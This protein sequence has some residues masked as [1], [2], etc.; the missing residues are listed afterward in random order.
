MKRGRPNRVILTSADEREL[1]KLYLQSNRTESGGSATMAARV[2]AGKNP[3]LAEALAARASKHDL[4]AAV[5]KAVEPAKRLVKLHREG[6]KGL[7]AT[8]GYNPG[9]MRLSEDGSRRL[10]AGEQICADDGTINFGVVVPWPWGGCKCS[11]KFGVKLGRF[12][13]LLMHDDATSLIPCW[14]YIIRPSQSY[15]AADVAGL[16]LRFC[17]DICL[18]DRALFEGGNWQSKRV[19]SALEALGIEL[20]DVKGRPNQKLVENFF[21]RLWT[22]ISIESN[23]SVGRFREDDRLGQELY[24]AGQD[25]RKDPRLS[26]PFLDDALQAIETSIRWENDERIESKV[27]G[28]WIPVER[29]AHDMIEHPRPRLSATDDHFWLA[30]PVLEERVVRRDMIEVTTTGPLGMTATFHFTSPALWELNGKRV[31]IAF[32]PLQNPCEA[33]IADI[34]RPRVLC[35]ATSVDPWNKDTDAATAEVKALRAIMRREYRSLMVDG[36]GAQRLGVKETEV[37]GIDRAVEIRSGSGAAPE[38]DGCDGRDGFSAASGSAVRRDE[39]PA[40]PNRATRADLSL[41]IR[42]RAAEAELMPEEANW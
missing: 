34:D 38:G 15:R 40:T 12:Q 8:A 5:R 9:R 6:E 19:F 39:T 33:I 1:A 20:V 16:L 26:F 28:K 29:W 23:G 42:R 31:R 37:R 41:S 36:D 4:P 18:P 17:R 3:A 10:F 2:L 27:Y 25:G 24:V 30:A 35:T 32:D 13:L 11:D 14:S 7:R 22:R 21:N